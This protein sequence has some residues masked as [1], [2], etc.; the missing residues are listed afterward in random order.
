M[1]LGK[2]ASVIESLRGGIRD[3]EGLLPARLAT[4]RGDGCIVEIGSYR[5]KSAAAIALGTRNALGTSF[6]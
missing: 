1:E 3:D 2:I 5:G 4:N 6:S